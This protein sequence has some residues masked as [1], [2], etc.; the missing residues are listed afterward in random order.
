MYTHA[1]MHVYTCISKIYFLTNDSVLQDMIPVASF[2]VVFVSKV[3]LINKSC[4]RTHPHNM[5]TDIYT[6]HTHTHT[7]RLW[8]QF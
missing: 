5:H 4:A 1:F 3:C 2:F 6:A 8:W 7:H